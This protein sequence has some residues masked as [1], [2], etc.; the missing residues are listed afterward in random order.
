MFREIVGR[1]QSRH[2][3]FADE[4]Y[5]NHD[6][7]KALT[8]VQ[9]DFIFEPLL[10]QRH[11]RSQFHKLSFLESLPDRDHWARYAEGQDDNDI[12]S[13]AE[14]YAHCF[15]H[16]SQQATDIRWLIAMNFIANDRVE[17][18]DINLGSWASKSSRHC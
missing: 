4:I 14:A 16:Q 1:I 7:L 8:N 9:F 13:L 2:D 18:Q 3:N 6:S 15:N 17:Y 11:H 5:L 10:E 12:S